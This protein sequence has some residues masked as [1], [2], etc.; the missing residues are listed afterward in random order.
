LHVVD[1]A[2]HSFRVAEKEA[3]ALDALAAWML[4]LAQ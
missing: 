3:E 4:R 1:G 2:D